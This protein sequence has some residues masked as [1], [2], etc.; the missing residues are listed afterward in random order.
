MKVLIVDDEIIIREGIANVIPW[1]N[2][3]YTLLKPASS[4]EDAL[5]QIDTEYP[6]ILITDIRMTGMTGLELVSLIEER[7]YQ[8][9]S[10]LLTGYDDFEY[11]QE[12]IRQNVCDYLL[13]NSSPDDIILAVERAK[14]RVEITKEYDQLK[15]SEV[16]HYV[17]SQLRKLV[18]NES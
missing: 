11:I 5:K 8:I 12:A 4:A 15:E 7:N 2:L 18:E 6:D 16:E 14:K 13:K 17:S 10:I 3:G 9:E 1:D